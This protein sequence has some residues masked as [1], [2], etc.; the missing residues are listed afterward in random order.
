[1]EIDWN[2]IIGKT[3]T[4]LM[5]IFIPLIIM[6]TIHWIG[7]FYAKLKATKPDLAKALAAAAQIGYCAAEEYFRNQKDIDGNDKMLF[8]IEHAQ[9]Y[10][11]E[12]GVS[13]DVRAIR[14]AIHAFGIENGKF[15]W[16][17]QQ[18]LAKAEEYEIAAEQTEETEEENPDE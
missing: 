10:L 8:A 17:W 15:S 13:I 16:Q 18:A 1:M 4:E 5:K 7:D 11:S 6:L 9:N 14:D 2:L 12:L 3:I